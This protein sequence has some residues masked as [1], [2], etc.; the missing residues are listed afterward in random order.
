MT[1]PG[2]E[3]NNGAAFKTDL[4]ALLPHL[5]AFARSLVF[6]PVA[7][8]DLVQDTLL[9]SWARRAG[10]TPGTNLKAWTFT[11]L[12][13]QFYSDTRRSWRRVDWDEEK[14]ERT[15]VAASNPEDVLALDELRRALTAL[16]DDQREALI[17][18]GAGG[19]SYEEAAEICG[20][21]VGTMK[22]RV[23][24]ARRT[25]EDVFAHRGFQAEKDD[26]SAT[27]AMDRLLNDMGRLVANGGNST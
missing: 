19:F 24:R 6:D 20:C 27:E 11:I 5:R 3:A 7:A 16:S 1:G 4:V 18:I 23:N 25:L 26:V 17:L 9:K 13:N 12:R 22:S 21:A 8:D 14:A 10:F 2:S 15:L